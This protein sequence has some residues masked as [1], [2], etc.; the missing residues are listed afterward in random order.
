MRQSESTYD[1][2]VEQGPACGS[3]ERKCS[4]SGNGASAE[5]VNGGITGGLVKAVSRSEHCLKSLLVG[6]NNFIVGK[7]F[8]ISRRELDAV[9][10]VVTSNYSTSTLRW[11][12]IM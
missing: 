8:A 10:F 3:H 5:N 7:M 11:R 4:S 6:Q 9:L 12:F 1:I 2:R